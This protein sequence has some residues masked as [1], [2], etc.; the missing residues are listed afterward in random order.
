MPSNVP[1][2]QGVDELARPI[3]AEVGVDH[4][5]AA[6]DRAVDAVDDRRRE[7][8]V[9]LAALVAGLDRRDRARAR[10]RPT[11]WTIAS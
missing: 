8:F 7:E 4:R 3:R 1:I 9:V 6:A 11:P 10:A 5:V 2:G